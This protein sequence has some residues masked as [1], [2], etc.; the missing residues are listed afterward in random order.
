MESSEP[1]KQTKSAEELAG[2]IREDLSRV[3]GC[4]KYGVNVTV[5]GMG[6]RQRLLRGAHPPPN[7]VKI[8]GKLIGLYRKY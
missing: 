5:Y 7:R 1:A 8:Q 6:A 4:P 2:M 3:N